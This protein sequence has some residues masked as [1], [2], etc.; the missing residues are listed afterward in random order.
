MNLGFLEFDE[1]YS[2]AGVKAMMCSCVR[3]PLNYF[4]KAWRP[5][6]EELYVQVSTGVKVTAAKV[7]IW[8]P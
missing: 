3:W 6:D 4:L 8:V 2:A 7:V 1:G 5:D